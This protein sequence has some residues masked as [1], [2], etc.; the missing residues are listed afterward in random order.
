MSKEMLELAIAKAILTHERAVAGSCGSVSQ[1]EARKAAR[2][3]ADIA[4][5][6]APLVAG[7]SAVAEPV[8]WCQPMDCGKHT[9]RKFLLYFEDADRGIAVFDDEAEARAALRARGHC[10]ELLP[11][12]SAAKSGRLPRA[13]R[14]RCRELAGGAGAD[15]Q[16]R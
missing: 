14:A 11:L 1:G 4:A 9:P 8:A 2:K 12:R 13:S 5:A 10:M 6:I 7:A 3:A 15:C 16:G